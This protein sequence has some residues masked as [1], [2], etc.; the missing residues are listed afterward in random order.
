MLSFVASLWHEGQNCPLYAISCGDRS[1]ENLRSA[2]I[3]FE[4]FLG[5]KNRYFRISEEYGEDTSEAISDVE[6]ALEEIKSL[7][8]QFPNTDED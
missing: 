3:L 8:S 4:R 6:E 7:L 2:E 5:N 1:Q